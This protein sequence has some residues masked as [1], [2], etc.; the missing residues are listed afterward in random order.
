MSPISITEPHCHHPIKWW[1]LT[2]QLDLSLSL[3]TQHLLKLPQAEWRLACQVLRTWVS[4][5]A[6]K[7]APQYNPIS[8][9]LHYWPN[10]FSSEAVCRQMLN[11]DP[12]FRSEDGEL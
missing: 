3:W 8:T 4:G 11:P 7:I 9:T 1:T 10:S 6:K 12:T 5:H 2:L